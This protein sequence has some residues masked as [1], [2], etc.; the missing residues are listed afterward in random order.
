L[1]KADCVMK[2]EDKEMIVRGVDESARHVGMALKVCYGC[3][4]RES[5]DKTVE[6]PPASV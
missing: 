6:I 3:D 1:F 5:P 4:S 2:P